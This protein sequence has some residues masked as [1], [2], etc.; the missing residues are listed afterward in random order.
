MQT[1]IP[2]SNDLKGE[3]EADPLLPLSDKAHRQEPETGQTP[4]PLQDLHGPPQDGLHPKTEI[5]Q[6]EEGYQTDPQT[7]PYK[8]DL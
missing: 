6:E 3:Q 5:D 4:S 8:A 2:R 1:E 7:Y